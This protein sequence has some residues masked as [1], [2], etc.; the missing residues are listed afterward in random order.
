MVLD[1]VTVLRF[2]ETEKQRE[3]MLEEKN[4]DLQTRLE[5][6]EKTIFARLTSLHSS[7]PEGRV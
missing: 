7:S 6:V 5:K 1:R 3:K 2:E 4:R